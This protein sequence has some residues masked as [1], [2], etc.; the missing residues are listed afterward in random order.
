MPGETDSS[1]TIDSDLTKQH[2]RIG[3]IPRL[4]E[5][6]AAWDPAADEPRQT[7]MLEEMQ[8]ALD[9]VKEAAKLLRAVPRDRLRPGASRGEPVKPP[10]TLTLSGLHFS[11]IP[12]IRWPTWVGPWS[13]FIS[14]SSRIVGVFAPDYPNEA[15]VTAKKYVLVP[16]S[17][18]APM[19]ADDELASTEV[20]R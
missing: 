14:P 2:L 8:T 6:L 16:Y 1:F 7:E 20:E 12:R 5:L 19:E 18:V 11:P 17:A 13:E 3:G 10:A 15:P 4:R 9:Q